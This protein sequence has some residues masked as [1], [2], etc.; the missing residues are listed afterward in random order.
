MNPFQYYTINNIS[1]SQGNNYVYII[2]FQK[3]DRQIDISD[4]RVIILFI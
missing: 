4:K 1:L 2:L 3:F